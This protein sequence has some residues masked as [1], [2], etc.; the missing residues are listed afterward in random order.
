MEHVVQ[1]PGLGIELKVNEVAFTIGSFEIKWYGVIIGVGFILAM[2]Y[3]FRS[4]KVMKVNE[5]KFIDA[6]L[7]GLIGG[8]IGARLYFVIFYPG[9][10][11]VQN[12]MEIFNIRS[13]GLGFYGGMI[14]GLLCGG[15]MARFRKLNIP[16]VFDL[17][18]MSFLIAQSIGRWGNFVNQEAFGSETNLPWGMMSDYTGNVTVH[19]CFLYESILCLIGFIFLHIFTRKLRRYDGQTFLLYIGWYGLIR[20]FIESLR[21]DSLYIGGLKVSMVV[22]ALMVIASVVL[23]IIF[24]NRTSLTGCGNKAVMEANAV[25]IEESSEDEATVENGDKSVVKS[26]NTEDN[27]ESGEFDPSKYSTIFGDL[28]EEKNEDGQE[29]KED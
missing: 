20:F 25:L 26:V 27:S 22:S 4:L 16:A 13:G 19:P 9:D 12:P 6:I 24:R 28:N 10:K 5:D 11:Y 8:I 18:S 2:I 21:T 29:E 17:V 14:G 1:F 15:L 23:L 7:V 3:A